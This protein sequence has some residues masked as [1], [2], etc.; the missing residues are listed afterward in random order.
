MLMR[1]RGNLRVRPKCCGTRVE[2]YLG[3]YAGK[4]Y[5]CLECGYIEFII[6]ETTYESYE[7]FKKEMSED[8]EDGGLVQ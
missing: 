4:L 1:L 2:P 5:C 3:G 7:S 8:C 6:F